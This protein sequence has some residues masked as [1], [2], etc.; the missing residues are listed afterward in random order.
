MAKRIKKAAATTGEPTKFTVKA[1]RGDFKTLLAFNLPEKDQKNLAGFTIQVQPPTGDPYYLLNSLQFE[2]STKHTQNKSLPVGSS[3]NSPFQKFRW[4]H[5]PGSYHQ[6][7]NPQVGLY[8]YAVTPRYFLKGVLQPIDNTKTV[9]T[10][11]TVAPFETGDLQLGF[12]R[13]FVQSQAFENH[14]GKTLVIR[15]RGDA[16]DLQFDTRTVAGKNSLGEEF[17]FLDEYVWSGST[18]RKLIFD[19]LEEVKNDASLSID[20]FAYDFNEPDMTNYFL[21]FAKQGRIRVILDNAP[22]HVSTDAKTSD[23]DEFEE[24]FNKAVKGK[25]EKVLRGKFKRF[26]HD[27]VFIIKQKQADG[28]YVYQKVLT[29]STNFSVTGMYVNSNHILV[30]KND[31][32]ASLYGDV[33][34][35][36]W[37]N[38]VDGK[39]FIE[40]ELSDQTH[41]FAN[42]QPKL[43]ITFAPHAEEVATENLTK[44]ANRVGEETGSVFFAVMALQKGTGPVLPAVQNIH[45]NTKVFSMGISDSPDGIY[46]YKPTQ[47]E[48]ILVTGKPS[49]VQLPPPFNQEPSIGL[50]H[51]IHH[52]FIVCGFNSENPTV[53]CGSSNLALGGEMSNGDNLIT[54]YSAEVATVF[55]I[56]AMALVDHFHFRNSHQGESAQAKGAKKP[57]KKAAK[58]SSAAGGHT[59]NLTPDDSWAKPYYTKN[60]LRK[61][62]R[63]LFA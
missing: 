19:I 53:Y 6:K 35:Q 61:K 30:F 58:K 27:K 55:A 50:G 25:G 59:F 16:A 31:K 48:G 24:R 33:F 18:A 26:A 63:E 12:T 5:V 40:S 46:L 41:V 3:L 28:S 54:I 38:K 39:A 21:D 44:I 11:I 15:P 22:L 56:E 20:V 47:G 34:E 8:E 29:G 62:D 2:T 7:N 1:H 43:E 51:Q 9:K 17:T 32:V 57:A 42:H 36:A 10:Q 45:K 13:G 37:Q 14:F 4:L 60:N 52:K 49:K 23:E